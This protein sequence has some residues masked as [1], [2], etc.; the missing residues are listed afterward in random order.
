MENFKIRKQ[1]ITENGCDNELSVIALPINLTS[2]QSYQ[3]IEKSPVMLN[4]KQIIQIENYRSNKVDYKTAQ[5]CLGT[6]HVDFF[7][8]LVNN[9]TSEDE[10]YQYMIK[11]CKNHGHVYTVIENSDG[12]HQ[13]LL[14]AKNVKPLALQKYYIDKCID[15]TIDVI[16]NLN[17]DIFPL[18]NPQTSEHK[19]VMAAAINALLTMTNRELRDYSTINAYTSTVIATVK[20][21]ILAV[22]IPVISKIVT[23][24]NIEC[25]FTLEQIQL[26]VI[27][28]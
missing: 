6:Y 7:C 16:F 23:R 18:S 11:G 2:D 8:S 26:S 20:P 19:S 1:T 24:F 4:K 22:I 3:L 13:I 10:L 5:R 27:Y 14:A 25:G 9:C 15:N 21:S 17:I 12:S 28:S